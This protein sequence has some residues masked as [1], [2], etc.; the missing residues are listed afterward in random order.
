MGACQ[1]LQAEHVDR[2][3]DALL[4]LAHESPN[5]FTEE[6]KFPMYVVPLQTFMHMTAVQPFEVLMQ[7]E[8][9]VR[10]E[11][12][13]GDAIFVSHQW[14]G[15][16]HP[17]PDFRQ[18]RVLQGALENMMRSSMEIPG[19]AL[20]FVILGER[21]CFHSSELMASALFIW[22]DYFCCPQ[23]ETK[24]SNEATSDLQNAVDSIP[25]YVYRAKFFFVLAPVVQH[26]SDGTLIGKKAWKTRGWCRVER[27]AREFQD[28]PRIV[29]VDSPEIQTLMEPFESMLAPPGEGVFSVASDK[30]R[31]LKFMKSMLQTH[32]CSLLQ[33]AD[34]YRYRFL[35]N[36]YRTH[37]EAFSVQVAAASTRANVL[38][39]VE[40]SGS[41]AE[42]A[43][44]VSLLVPFLRENGFRDVWRREFGWTP[45]C[46]AAL[47]GDPSIL[48]ALLHLRADVNE[49]VTQSDEEHHIH[50]H[51]TLLHVCAQFSNNDGLKLLIDHKAD[52][53]ARGDKTGCTPLHRAG[54]GDNP[55]GVILLLRAGCD[56][57]LREKLADQ[58]VL[59]PAWVWGSQ[60][61][62]QVMLEHIPG[63]DISC[64]LHFGI[65]GGSNTGESVAKLIAAGADINEQFRFL[66]DRWDPVFALLAAFFRKFHGSKLSFIIS[67]FYGA[68]PLAISLLTSSLEAASYLIEAGADVNIRNA[69]GLLPIELAAATSAPSYMV[70]RLKEKAAHGKPTQ[71]IAGVALETVCI[72]F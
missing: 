14:A 68:T 5:V 31:V 65:L 12:H 51:N 34:L 46:F 60:R 17:D 27:V 53:N 7:K 20:A 9:L 29:Y 35:L 48:E 22:Y 67:N 66:P 71:N 55:E 57:Y 62:V 45:V 28:D 36:R 15:Q 58:N 32:L 63:L 49:E 59:Y 23:L 6:L 56:P 72:S 33:T 4:H 1:G 26:A 3:D 44:L 54:I 42:S 24:P 64:L 19:P 39:P 10:Y 16:N 37:L 43:S 8:A 69:C 38:A 2:V 13:M 41:A 47:R 70:Q 52:I 18:L 25:G 61:A 11:P 40:P 30:E 21:R 50:A